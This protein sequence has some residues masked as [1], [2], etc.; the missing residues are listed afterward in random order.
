MVRNPL[1]EALE[2]GDYKAST[3]VKK[4]F[5]KRNLKQKIFRWAAYWKI[6]LHVIETSKNKNPSCYFT[7]K[8]FNLKML[9]TLTKSGAES[10]C[11]IVT[12]D[13]MPD[14]YVTFHEI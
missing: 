10:V 3:L 1:I 14:F 2:P 11:S 9:E 7:Q 12:P 13:F 5:L 4:E 8:Q 6:A